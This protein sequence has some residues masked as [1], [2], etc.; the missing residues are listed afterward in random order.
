M[1]NNLKTNMNLGDIRKL[2]ARAKLAMIGT[3]MDVSNDIDNTSKGIVTYDVVRFYRLE[4]VVTT[5]SSL[6][7]DT[8]VGTEEEAYLMA[9]RISTANGIK[10]KSMDILEA[11]K[12]KGSVVLDSIT[13]HAANGFSKG[14]YWLAKAAAKA[15]ERLDEKK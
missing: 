6:P 14:A 15:A 3:A 2:Y 11:V 7:D 13:V 10:T 5:L 8:K 12:S 9:L 1:M 4:F